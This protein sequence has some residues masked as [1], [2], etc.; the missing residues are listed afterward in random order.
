MRQDFIRLSFSE[1][2]L[3]GADGNLS[4]WVDVKSRNAIFHR[5]S[6]DEILPFEAVHTLGAVARERVMK[7]ISPHETIDWPSSNE[8]A[9]PL[10][11]PLALLA[12]MKR[13]L[14]SLRGRPAA[15]PAP[16]RA[17]VNAGLSPSGGRVAKEPQAASLNP[18]RLRTVPVNRGVAEPERP[19]N[20]VSEFG[21]LVLD[22]VEVL[23]EA[24]ASGVSMF[25]VFKNA[26]GESDASAYQAGRAEPKKP[27]RISVKA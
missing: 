22:K 18:G 2:D 6:G 12:T 24:A 1:F 4:V 5:P 23:A 9:P 21:R 20:K 8:G 16:A 13:S 19:Q 3:R 26:F 11:L 15:P 17:A 25:S 7:G 14:L 10:K 27:S